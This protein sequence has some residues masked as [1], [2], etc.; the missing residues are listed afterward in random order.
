MV[1]RMTKKGDCIEIGKRLRKF[2]KSIWF[3]GK[4]FAQKLKRNRSYISG[5]ENGHYPLSPKL[6]ELIEKTFEIDAT[7]LLEGVEFNE[8]I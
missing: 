3:S 2:R 4:D 8:R 6:V 1:L 7:F 5:V